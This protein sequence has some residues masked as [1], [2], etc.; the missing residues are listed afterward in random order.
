MNHLYRPS[1]LLNATVSV[2]KT[3]K[4]CNMWYQKFR[5]F[6]RW[7]D[8]ERERKEYEMYQSKVKNWWRSPK[9]G[10][11]IEPDN[12]STCKFLI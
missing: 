6:K 10:M 1:S 8:I 4:R 2:S 5:T 3:P 12:P 11:Y 7:Q 9:T